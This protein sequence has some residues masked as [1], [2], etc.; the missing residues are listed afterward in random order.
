MTASK[1]FVALALAAVG[2]AAG[3]GLVHPFGRPTQNAGGVL[4]GGAEIRDETRAIIERACSNC[5]SEQGKWPWYSHFAPV[6]WLIENDVRGA[7]SHMNLSH[8]SGY[9]PQEREALLSAIGAAVRTG[10]MPPA[11]Y[12]LLHK[13]AQLSPGERMSIYEWSRAERR[14]SRTDDH[15]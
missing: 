7:R 12:R 4:L 10:Q 6:S 5:H 1:K 8:W 14:R 2:I 3:G 15:P 13:E 11:R 9:T